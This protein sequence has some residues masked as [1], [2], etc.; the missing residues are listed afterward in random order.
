MSD[1]NFS[2]I[3]IGVGSIIFLVSA[4]LPISKVYALPTP[5]MKLA[6]INKSRRAWQVSQNLFF[7]GALLM[8]LG[9]IFLAFSNNE[10]SSILALY[11]ASGLLV[12]GLASWSWHLYLRT[13]D[14]VAFVKGALPA[15]HFKLYTVFT[16]AALFLIGITF[17]GLGFPVWGSW[18]IMIGSTLFFV[19]FIIFKDLPPFALYLLGLFIS[20]LFFQAG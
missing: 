13:L 4:F 9:V 18:A 1:L 5:E 19:L 15:W 11:F 16:L 20:F 14:P 8:T 10:N 3:F 2:A 6:L 7:F 17:L 12:L